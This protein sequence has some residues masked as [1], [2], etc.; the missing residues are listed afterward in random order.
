MNV[1]RLPKRLPFRGK[2]E[3]SAY[4][5]DARFC[6]GKR[7]AADYTHELLNGKITQTIS[8]CHSICSFM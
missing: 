1:L 5:D 2:S 8:D 6:A 3:I 7:N 4:V